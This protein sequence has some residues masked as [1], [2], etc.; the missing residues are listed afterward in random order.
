MHEPSADRYARKSTSKTI[1]RVVPIHGEERARRSPDRRSRR[2]RWSARLRR[3]GAR[4]SRLSGPTDEHA[5][6]TSEGAPLADA[7]DVDALDVR[8][9]RHTSGRS[10]GGARPALVRQRRR[11]RICRDQ[12]REHETPR[13]GQSV[14]D[15]GSLAPARP[16][17]IRERL[18]ASRFGESERRLGPTTAASASTAPRRERQPESPAYAG[19]PH[20][21]LRQPAPPAGPPEGHR[22]PSSAIGPDVHGAGGSSKSIS[23]PGVT[24]G[25]HNV[26]VLAT[27][28]SGRWVRAVVPRIGDHHRPRR[29]SPA[30]P[31][32]SVGPAEAGRARVEPPGQYERDR[33]PDT[34]G[35]RHP[36]WRP[37]SEVRAGGH[38]AQPTSRMRAASG[39]RL[40]QSRW[41]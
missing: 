11:R 34:G 18:E 13:P 5:R 1:R 26:A 39:R 36:T 16:H 8:G 15:H 24:S 21:A 25:S 29:R 37:S 32:S 10:R 35:S 19:D 33:P 20:R 40:A 38:G 30:R 3:A 9:A 41:R 7:L 4:S 28:R 6:R 12:R 31:T 14:D 22:A 23:L 27:N 2:Y 17:G